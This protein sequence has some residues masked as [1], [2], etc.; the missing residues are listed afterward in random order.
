MKNIKP[1]VTVAVCAY[2]EEKNISAF[3]ST[4]LKQAE[5]SFKIMQIIVVSDGSTDDT[6]SKV[7][8]LK[9]VRIQLWNSHERKGK[10]YWLNKIYRNLKTDFLVQ[11]DADVIF[12]N[13]R[14][15]SSILKPMLINK[16]VFM[17]G[18][19]P[20]PI[21][22][23]TFIE[24]SVNITTKTYRIFRKSVRGGNNVF[25]ADGRL[26]AYRTKFIKGVIIPKT[27]I[28]NDAFTY[29]YCITKGGLYKFVPNAIVQYRSPQTVKDQIRQNTRFLASPQRMTKY[30]DSDIVAKEYEIP[31][32]LYLRT[33]IKEVISHPVHSIVIFF[34]NKLC[35][36]NSRLMESRLNGKWAMATTTKTE[37]N[38]V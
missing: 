9:E 19:N 29:F 5:E 16:K 13:D 17:C 38:R 26:L 1:T 36:I 37:I 15:I 2:N 33:I 34:I 12:T 31:T 8:S 20:E 23:T 3:L 28:A 25:S 4:V 35:F 10:S 27:M 7:N 6:V 30:F 22:G 14:V 18:G 24:K 11:S 21:P 32:W